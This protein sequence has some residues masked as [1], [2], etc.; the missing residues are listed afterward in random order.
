M[1]TTNEVSRR[2]AES[3]QIVFI[4]YGDGETSC[5]L[6]HQGCNCD[7][8]PYTAELG[9]GLLN[10]LKFYSSSNN[11]NIYIGDWHDNT[12][13]NSLLRSHQINSPQFANY[14]L[15]MNDDGAFG[16]DCMYNFLKTIQ[17]TPRKKIIISNEKNKK[18]KEL[19]NA[20]SYVTVPPNNWF[21]EFEK[22]FE[23]VKNEITD[24]CIVF[25]A[26]G[27]GSKVLVAEL[28]KRFPSLTCLDI[29]SSF[30]FLCQKTKSRAWGHTYE[31][32]YNYYKGILPENW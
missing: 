31:D 2:I 25:T 29:G 5:M 32:E 9:T 15:I 14:H 20:N 6:R 7:G 11:M 10:S 18:M 1:I 3:I 21:V 16:N 23:I 4:K 28:L 19:F 30:D 24:N 22:Y 8:D 17:E 13:I 26:A 12:V 27:Q